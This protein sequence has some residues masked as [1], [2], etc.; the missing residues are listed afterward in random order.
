[1]PYTSRCDDPALTPEE[2][3]VTKALWEYNTAEARRA[4]WV[5]VPILY[6]VYRSW[7]AHHHRGCFEQDKPECLTIRQ[8]GRAVNRIFP[9]V[10]RCKRRYAGREHYGFSHLAGPL[11]IQSN[12]R[13]LLGATRRMQLAAA[14]DA[15]V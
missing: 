1:M 7:Y 8:F 3:D 15:S 5:P 2:E 14:R 9:D 12:E 10:K 6:R 11:V 4:D 13:R